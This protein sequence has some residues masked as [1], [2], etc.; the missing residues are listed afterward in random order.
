L[1]KTISDAYT[2][3]KKQIIDIENSLY[4][5]DEILGVTDANKY[6]NDAFEV[7]I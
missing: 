5:A 1:T 3:A 6:K 7:Y 4:D 2:S